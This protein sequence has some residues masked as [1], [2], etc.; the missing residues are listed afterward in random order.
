LKKR[1]STREILAKR[2]SK[3]VGQAFQPDSQAEENGRFSQIFLLVGLKNAILI[4]LG[5]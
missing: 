2:G 3:K 4:I 5:F 1:D